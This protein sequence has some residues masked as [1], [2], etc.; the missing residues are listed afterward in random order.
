MDKKNLDELGPCSHNC[1]WELADD[2]NPGCS[3]SST[4]DCSLANLLEAEE[5]GF[6]DAGLIQATK[7]IKAILSQ[8]PADSAGRSLS[9][10]HTK[11]GTLLAWVEHGAEPIE[12]AVT[13]DAD[14]KTVAAA[15]KLKV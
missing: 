12:G 9:F 10:L 4:P 13:S 7:E 11:M 2:G 1:S 6:H 5:S 3:S 14:N 15:L 8:I